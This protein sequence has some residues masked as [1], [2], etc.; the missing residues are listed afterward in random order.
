MHCNPVVASIATC[1]C[2]RTHT[3]KV[4][5]HAV[6]F[7]QKSLIVHLP[8]EL[9]QSLRQQV[10]CLPPGFRRSCPCQ[11]SERDV[12]LLVNPLLDNVTLAPHVFLRPGVFVLI[13]G[14]GTGVVDIVA[15]VEVDI[16]GVLGALPVT[17][18]LGEVGCCAVGRVRGTLLIVDNCG[19][20]VFGGW[21]RILQN[22]QRLFGVTRGLRHLEAESQME[23]HTWLPDFGQISGKLPN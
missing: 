6:Y 22:L 5:Q 4:Q 14:V 21:I 23:T 2:T 10:S 15:R 12:G 8:M 16:G 17:G 3:V 9:L 19:H 13:V 20:P 1:G 11:A 18:R 7:L